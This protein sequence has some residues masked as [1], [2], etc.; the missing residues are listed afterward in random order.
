MIK[1]TTAVVL[2]TIGLATPA[3]SQGMQ[4]MKAMDHSKMDHSQMGKGAMMKDT[5]AN[6]YAS[7]GMDMMQKMM[8]AMGNDA[9]ETWTRKMIE[10]HR[11]AISMSRIALDKAKDQDTRAMAQKTITEQEKDIT[12]LQAMLTRKG[13]TAQ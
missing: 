3:L 5:P 10:H 12:D 2:V 6:P 1:F 7:T 4:G 13:K 9:G 8:A 11:G